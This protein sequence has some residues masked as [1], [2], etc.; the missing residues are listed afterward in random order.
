MI[1]GSRRDA[2]SLGVEISNVGLLLTDSAYS[3]AAPRAGS[4]K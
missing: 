1:F 2:C 4:K 3:A